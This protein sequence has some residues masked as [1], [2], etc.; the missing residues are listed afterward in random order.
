MKIDVMLPTYDVTI[1]PQSEIPKLLQAAENMLN[2]ITNPKLKYQFIKYYITIDNVIN[3][4]NG[5]IE[6]CKK[7]LEEEKNIIAIGD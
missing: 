3:F 7:A 2:N 6:L 4:A 5:L 1:I